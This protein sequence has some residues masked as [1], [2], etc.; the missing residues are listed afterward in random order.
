LNFF[1]NNQNGYYSFKGS[2]GE[3]LEVFLREV[4]LR[5]YKKASIGTRLK[6]IVKWFNFFP[7]F[8]EG[9]SSHWFKR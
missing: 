8:L 2:K 7:K 4:F 1:N 3:D 6:I 5:E 9:T